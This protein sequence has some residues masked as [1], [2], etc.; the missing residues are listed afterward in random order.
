MRRKKYRHDST[1]Y[2]RKRK[3]ITQGSK[4]R[5]KST[6]LFFSVFFNKD[7]LKWQHAENAAKSAKINVLEPLKLKNVK[8]PIEKKQP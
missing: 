3:S 7:I 4:S 6:I 5:M 2:F 8:S 1:I